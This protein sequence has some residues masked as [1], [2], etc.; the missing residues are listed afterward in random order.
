M[1]KLAT[2]PYLRLLLSVTVSLISLYAFKPYEMET[3]TRIMICWNFFGITFLILSWVTFYKKDSNG[4]RKT[5]AEQDSGHL[6]LFFILVVA[7]IISLAAIILLLKS[8]QEWLL[9]KETVTVIYFTGVLISWFLHQTLYTIHYAHLYY[10]ERNK[11]K[12]ILLFP[13]T[14]EPDYMDFAYFAFT[15]GMTFQVS[16]VSVNSGNLRRLV[17]LQSITSFGFNTII[18]A[19]SVNAIVSL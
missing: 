6:I 18:I 16:D 14:S 9:E 12:K 5:A 17:L 19:L 13:Y 11:E 1:N 15:N 7:T 4:I 10:N 8:E 3:L 2:N